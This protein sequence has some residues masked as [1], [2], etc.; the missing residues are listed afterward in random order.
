MCRCAWL[1]VRDVWGAQRGPFS[2]LFAF[3]SGAVRV[4]SYQNR[5]G[6]EDK[7]VRKSHCFCNI[8]HR[9][10]FWP[11]FDQAFLNYRSVSYEPYTDQLRPLKLVGCWDSMSTVLRSHRVNPLRELSDISHA[12]N[13]HILHVWVSTPPYS[14]SWNGNTVLRVCIKLLV[15][16]QMKRCLW[17]H[18]KPMSQ[19]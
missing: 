13:E 12:L 14:I 19:W 9:V 18:D 4:G 2:S 7:R 6:G 16:I 5:I 8:G 11:G 3:R 17:F 10:F 1:A 15:R